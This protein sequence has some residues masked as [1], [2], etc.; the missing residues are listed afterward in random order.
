MCNVKDTL[1]YESIYFGLSTLQVLRNGRPG[2]TGK[3]SRKSGA[4]LSTK[5]YPILRTNWVETMT[6]QRPISYSP[7]LGGFGSTGPGWMN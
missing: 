3:H 1:L 6:R 5:V 4:S 7:I 2:K